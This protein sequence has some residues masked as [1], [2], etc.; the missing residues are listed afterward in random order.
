[1]AETRPVLAGRTTFAASST[2]TS[3]GCSAI[4]AVT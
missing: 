2:D 1:M 3:V 4:I